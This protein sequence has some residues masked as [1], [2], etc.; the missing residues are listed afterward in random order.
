MDDLIYNQNKIPKEQWRYGLRSS[1]A[2]GCGWIA[3]YNALRL[4]GY[5]AE[6]EALIRYYERQVPLIH[7][8]AG[9]MLF[10]PALR[11]R[12]WGFPVKMIADRSNFDQA[13]K[14]ADVCILFYRW[15]KKY[16]YGAHFVALHHT[17]EGFIGYNT[18]RTSTGPDRYGPSLESFLK[19]R[20]YFGAVLITIQNKRG[21]TI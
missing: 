1:A 5:R 3:T 20:K 13:A 6:P 2:T 8:N 9:T 17:E 18:Y 7:G 11:F 4:M 19:K 14:E 21:I 16:K 12:K 10:A 15:F